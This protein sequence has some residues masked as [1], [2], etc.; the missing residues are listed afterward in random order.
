MEIVKAYRTSK[1][2]F[3]SKE[4]ALKKKNRVRVPMDRFEME[5]EPVLEVMLLK[6][7]DFYFKLDCVEMKGEQ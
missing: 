6:D 4:E 5:R 7:G 1:G 3:Y 2:T